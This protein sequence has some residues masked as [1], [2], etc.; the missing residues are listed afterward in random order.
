VDTALSPEAL[1]VLGIDDPKL[2][3]EF[4]LHF[5]LPL[6]LQAGGQTTK[7]F[8]RGAEREVPE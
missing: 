4:F 6:D 2:Q 8:W 7:R 1:D 5:R 3:S